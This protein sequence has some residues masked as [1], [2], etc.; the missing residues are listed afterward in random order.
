LP[1]PRR[2]GATSLEDA[3][4]RRR[5]VRDFAA[6][7]LTNEQ[8]GQLLWAAQGMTNRAQGLRAAP[9]AGALYPLEVFVVSATGTYLYEPNAHALVRVRGGDLRG[10]LARAAADQPSVRQAPVDLVIAALVARTRLKYG[11]RAE[12]YVALEA[13]HAA[14]DVLLEATA[15]GLGAV[16]VGAFDDQD[17]RRVLGLQVGEMPLYLLPIGYPK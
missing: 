3:I 2:S 1:A 15:L 9:S 8:I 10:P 17:V 7:A 11:D 6:R 12:R 16:P 4:A 13:G 14:Q 5:S